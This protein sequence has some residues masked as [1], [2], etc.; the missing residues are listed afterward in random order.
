MIK[1]DYVDRIFQR[2]F[3]RLP[4]IHPS[5]MDVRLDGEPSKRSV[6]HEEGANVRL[7]FAEVFGERPPDRFD[8]PF[9]HRERRNQPRVRSFSECHIFRV[10][11]HPYQVFPRRIRALDA[12]SG[13]DLLY[14]SFDDVGEIET[15]RFR[16][17]T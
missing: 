17:T 11:D 3:D 5:V 13:A 10:V 16:R 1:A 12:Q 4:P 6:I 14:H 15:R 9:A 7:S 8:A 2:L